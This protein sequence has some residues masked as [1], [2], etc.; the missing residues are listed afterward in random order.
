LNI[1]HAK[2]VFS[3]NGAEVNN[4]DEISANSLLYISQGEPFFRGGDVSSSFIESYSISVLG[5]ASVGKSA[6]TLRYVRDFFAKD[7]DPTI[8]DAYK[9]TVEIDG[10]PCKLEILDTA[11]Q[12]VR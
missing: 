10:K 1:K 12:D 7:W 3:E 9:K 6:I 8:E 2:I 11:G 5:T 4:I